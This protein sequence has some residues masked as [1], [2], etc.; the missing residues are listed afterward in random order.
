MRGAGV[1]GEKR[2]ENLEYVQNL[3]GECG[4]DA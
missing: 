1:E 3:M 4:Y 2:H